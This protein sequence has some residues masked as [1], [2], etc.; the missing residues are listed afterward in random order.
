MSDTATAF[1]PPKMA[2]IEPI[3]PIETTVIHKPSVWLTPNNSE[4]LKIL[5]KFIDPV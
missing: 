2:Y 5:S 3:T 4:I 1:N